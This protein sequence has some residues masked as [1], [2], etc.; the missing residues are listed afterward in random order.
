MG[1][2]KCTPG[3]PLNCFQYQPDPTGNM[4]PG[5][6]ERKSCAENRHGYSF[7]GD[8]AYSVCSPLVC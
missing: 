7:S 2:G 5:L 4:V 3:K 8:S 1:I 6:L